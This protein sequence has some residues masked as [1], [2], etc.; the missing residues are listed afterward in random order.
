MARPAGACWHRRALLRAGVAGVAAAV[1]GATR[2][3]AQ[4]KTSREDAAYQPTSNGRL[5]CEVC[6]LFRPPHGCAVVE[7]DIS[8][9]GWCKFFAMPD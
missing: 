8:P 4:A 2:T 5:S 3:L 9:R 7:G 6:S 1:L